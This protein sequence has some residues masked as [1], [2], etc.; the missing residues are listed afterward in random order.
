MDVKAEW[1]EFG[2]AGAGS[3]PV[4]RDGSAAGEG[5]CLPGLRATA[6]GD[7]PG[8]PRYQRLP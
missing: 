1:I 3:G 5:N 4:F 8:Q 7:L 6:A 2:K